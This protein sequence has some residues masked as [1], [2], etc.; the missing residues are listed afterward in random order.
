LL[1]HT[2][3]AA[4]SVPG[5]AP[6]ER[7]A[8][9]ETAPVREGVTPGDRAGLL[10]SL[11]VRAVAVDSA[12]RVAPF[13]PQPEPPIRH[14]GR[15]RV[16]TT[17]K[18]GTAVAFADVDAGKLS[19]GSQALGN[20]AIRGNDD[21]SFDWTA[22]VESPGAGAMRLRFTGF[23]LP[24]NAELYVYGDQGDVYGP[25]IGRGIHG[26]GQFWSHTV[27]GSRVTL[28]LSYGGADTAR[29]LRVMRFVIAD[30]AH[31]DRGFPFGPSAQP[32]ASN[33][34][35]FN[36]DC[37]ENASSANIPAAIQ[38]AQQ[39]AALILFVSGR[40]VYICSGGLIA[41]TDQNSTRPLFL[42]A[43]HCLSKTSEARS[44]EAYFQFTTPVGG[45]CDLIAS[46]VRGSSVLATGR[47]GDFTLL[48]LDE[49]PPTGSVLLGWTNTPVA[50]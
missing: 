45:S 14:E 42:T 10:A 43:N 7:Q 18:L 5:A 11:R 13:A 12:T 40:Y 25:Y 47:K 23:F 41:D 4:E 19:R 21:G 26:D 38:L 6:P 16:G 28:H 24:R 50:F 49:Q 39:A 48:E 35:S 3:A 2:A 46:S 33:L 1:I 17:R 32:D 9:L 22:A 20:G 31:L 15:V 27:S 8:S 44:L 30:V 29:V 37:V 36:A 34:C